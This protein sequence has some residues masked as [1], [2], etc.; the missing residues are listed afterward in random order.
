MATTPKHRR[1]AAKL[2]KMMSRLMTRHGIT[3]P[4][5]ITD[6]DRVSVGRVGRLV[7]PLFLGVVAA[8]EVP[9]DPADWR[10]G[11]TWITTTTNEDGFYIWS[12][13]PPT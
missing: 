13:Q 6:L 2:I 3:P 7:D 9:D 10:P 12:Y 8:I 11:G 4:H 1:R 5:F